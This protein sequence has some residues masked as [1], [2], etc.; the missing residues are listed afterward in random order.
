VG[1][2]HLILYRDDFLGLFNLRGKGLGK[3]G[4]MARMKAMGKMRVGVGKRGAKGGG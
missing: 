1:F 3:R 4:K 2:L